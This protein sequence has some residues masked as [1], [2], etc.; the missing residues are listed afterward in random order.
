[1][2]GDH[3][4]PMCSATFTRPQHVGRHLRAH[5]GDRPYE[6]KDCP[7]KFARSDLLSRHVNKAHPKPDGG[8]G[9]GGAGGAG[10][11]SGAK[12]VRKPQRKSFS[13]PNQDGV[14]VRPA[15]DAVPGTAAPLALNQQG[16]LQAQR[17]YPNH[18]L[19]QQPQTAWSTHPLSDYTAHMPVQSKFS[20][21]LTNTA[22]G[23]QEAAYAQAYNI[24]GVLAPPF[25]SAP[26]RSGSSDQGA[27]PALA[28]SMPSFGFDLGPKKRACDLCNHSKVRCDFN[29]PCARCASRGIACTYN[30]PQ[31]TRSIA[32]PMSTVP[33]QALGPAASTVNPSLSLPPAPSASQS[34][35]SVFSSPHSTDSPALANMSATFPYGMR[36][37]SI[38][39]PPTAD[40]TAAMLTSNALSFGAA[41]QAAGRPPVP[42]PQWQQA[43]T[44]VPAH[45]LDLASTQGS[46]VPFNP[47]FA[48]P[49]NVTPAPNPYAGLVKRTSGTSSA[50]SS[51]QGYAATPSLT[52]SQSPAESDMPPE[53]RNSQMSGVSATSNSAAWNPLGQPTVEAALLPDGTYGLAKTYSVQGL[54]DPSTFASPNASA[55]AG[56]LPWMQTTATGNDSGIQFRPSFGVS[57]DEVSPPDSSSTTTYRDADEPAASS[58][59][60][61]R[62]SSAGVW[63]NAFDQMTLSD[64]A[65]ATAYALTDPVIADQVAQQ[66]QNER[67]QQEQAQ[68]QPASAKRPAYPLGTATGNGQSTDPTRMSLNDMKDL[69][70]MYMA[71]PLT[72]T[73]PALDKHIEDPLAYAASGISSGLTPRPALGRR[74]LSKS[75]SMPDLTSPMSTQ[76]FFSTYLTGT[77]PRPVDPQA[78]CLPTQQ[79]D[80]AI[81]VRP[82]D[83]DSWRLE[84]KQRQ[85]NFNIAPGGKM[86]GGTQQAGASSTASGMAGHATMRPPTATQRPALLQ[87]LAPERTP[88]FGPGVG[89]GAG[90]YEVST[91]L[92]L[93]TPAKLSSA[94]ASSLARPGNKRLA[95]QTLVPADGQKKTSLN[96]FDDSNL[97]PADA[98]A[99]ADAADALHAPAGVDDARIAMFYGPTSAAAPPASFFPSP[100]AMSQVQPESVVQNGVLYSSWPPLA[101]Q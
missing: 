47:S 89:V 71:D 64:P 56:S 59:H 99:D 32:Y 55:T 25:S 15:V 82:E 20:L 49:D 24:P 93:K 3:K 19:L 72:G 88:S 21:P 34:P 74:T 14:P 85:V 80:E 86:R 94:F 54:Q 48:L 96:V 43:Q 39:V 44:T 81:P 26:M 16:T 100:T 63:A 28:S 65:I 92:T 77:T 50:S 101:T 75:N 41:L 33:S 79:A 4:C 62:R 91:P 42:D 68:A 18:P 53:R 37:N 17:M 5:T 73:T 57:D 13:H 61:R 36:R 35:Q 84:I 45:L 98:D 7:L 1:M 6:C 70:K 95:S 67:R 27:G 90:A 52:S 29:T 60:H 23:S 83:I 11:G 31:R 30:K 69:W 10:A 22:L 9:K 38:A 46:T 76:A 12:D 40:Q 58:L 78:S 2:G 87:T 8:D 97:V 66:L 51:H